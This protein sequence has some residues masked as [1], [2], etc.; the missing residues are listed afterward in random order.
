MFSRFPLAVILLT[1]PVFAQSP[2]VSTY[3]RDG[4]S[5]VAIA[6][7]T[8]GNIYL[9]G[10]QIVD[11][12]TSRTSVLVVKLNQQ[13]PSFLYQIV[14]GGSGSDHAGG[15]AVDSQGNAF[16]VGTTV[17]ADFPA[18]VSPLTPSKGTTDPR[19]FLVKIDPRGFVLAA[20]VIGATAATATSVAVTAQGEVLVSGIAQASG[21]PATTGAFSMPDTKDRPYLMKFDATASR[22]I[23][24]ATGIG[25]TI[26][27]DPI[28]NIYL[29]G[30]TLNRDYPTT[31]GAYQPVLLTRFICFGF[32]R[33]LFPATNQYVTKVDPAASRLIYSTGINSGNASTESVNTGFAVD[34]AGNAY[35]TGIAGFGYPFTTQPQTGAV[36]PP[37]LTKLDANGQSLVFSIPQ[38]GGSLAI[39]ASGDLYASGV[40][41][42]A[43]GLFIAMPLPPLLIPAGLT[44][45]PAQCLPNGL[46]SIRQ[47]VVQRVDRLAG[48]V[49][50][51]QLLDGTN[52][53]APLIGIGSA[54]KVWAAGTTTH[55]DVMTTPGAPTLPNLGTG[56]LPGAY[57]A[58]FDLQQFSIAVVRP[59]AHCLVDGATGLRVGPVAPL[60][61]VT[62]FG[63]GMAGATV[64]FDDLPAKLLYVSDSQVNVAVPL[65]VGRRT[66]T[67]MKLTVNGFDAAPRQ[68]QVVNSNPSLFVNYFP[69]QGNCAVGGVSPFGVSRNENGEFNACQTP[70]K[71]GSVVSF[72]LNGIGILP[73]EELQGLRIP[74]PDSLGVDALVNG[75]SVEI[76]R[77]VADGDFVWRFDIRLPASF[78]FFG[79]PAGVTVAGLTVRL[80]NLLV[81]PKMV[82]TPNVFQTPAYFWLS[83]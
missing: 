75:R 51:A 34:A 40:I 26:A 32:C 67:V 46:T 25:G 66:V 39:N 29:A 72:Y 44:A 60:Q 80:N 47:A 69:V 54:G 9:T 73:F 41:T 1:L 10:D 81:G 65:D 17:S 58:A 35:V 64:T 2:I 50:T 79:S 68:L 45:P 12:V 30:N 59:V 71:P 23:F 20:N 70:A 76:V 74:S 16:V 31:P 14:L 21:F 7:D 36:G 49:S 5:P 57:I 33:V 63:S 18:S 11:P 13:G 78:A 4:F 42:P 53:S 8:S 61:L 19:P 55:P 82:G 3:L 52:L 27:L 28:G 43:S 37:F 38:G 6:T 48:T 15:I 83:P 62:I 22:L 77:V 24:S 56:P